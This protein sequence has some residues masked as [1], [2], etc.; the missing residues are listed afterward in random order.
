M[1]QRG[2]KRIVTLTLLAALVAISTLARPGIAQ[3]AIPDFPDV[4][5]NHWEW[6]YV[7]Q[8]A[9]LDVVRGYEDGTFRPQGEVT[10]AEFLALIVRAQ[11]LPAPADGQAQSPFT[12]VTQADWFFDPVQRAIAAGILVPAE[13]GTQFG[14]QVPITRAEVARFVVRAIDG[15]ADVDQTKTGE[16][17]DVPSEDPYFDWARKAAMYGIINGYPNGTFGPQRTATR[18]EATAM[19]VRAL[20]RQNLEADLPSAE[21]LQSVLKRYQDALSAMPSQEAASEIRA[22]STDRYF[23]MDMSNMK[24]LKADSRVSQ[25]W[26]ILSFTPI[27]VH[28]TWAAARNQG[29]LSIYLYGKLYEETT[30]TFVTVFKKNGASWIIA[31]EWG[32]G[33]EKTVVTSSSGN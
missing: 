31:D 3:A 6:A 20:N 27:E 16:F 17:R 11:G 32:L 29:K 5:Q 12:D 9:D 15:H 26:S 22:V 24:T 19:L 25:S 1:T 10:R 28:R 7:R 13:Y 21:A 2:F 8:L 33:D 4:P 18:A 23:N 30:I 14:P